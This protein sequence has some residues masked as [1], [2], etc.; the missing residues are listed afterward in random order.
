LAEEHFVD[1]DDDDDEGII[2]RK[3][4]LLVS[5]S[6]ESGVIQGKI[7]MSKHGVEK[8]CRKDAD[9]LETAGWPAI[10]RS[11]GQTG[12]FHSKI[13]VSSLEEDWVHV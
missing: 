6:E 8:E 2:G 9:G 12:A 3:N 4:A 13:G 5:G 10:G 1:D 7:H 11:G